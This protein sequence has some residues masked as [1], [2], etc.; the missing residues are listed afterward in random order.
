[1]PNCLFALV[2][3]SL[4]GLASAQMPEWYYSH[5]PSPNYTNQSNSNYISSP[6][7]P[8]QSNQ[9]N[10]SCYSSPNHS[11]QSNSSI[12]QRQL[13]PLLI[14][15][16]AEVLGSFDQTITGLLQ[17][18]QKRLPK[19]EVVRIER[20]LARIVAALTYLHLLPY[21]SYSHSKLELLQRAIST[22]NSVKRALV[23]FAEFQE[24]QS[25]QNSGVPEAQKLLAQSVAKV[26]QLLDL[27]M[28]KVEQVKTDSVGHDQI[29]RD[30]L[31]EDGRRLKCLA[32]ATD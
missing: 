28:G 23:Q 12:F 3:L 6:A 11:N 26:G 8:Y 9:T 10:H 4:A 31:S 14:A 7:S 30:R 21:D 1:M 15:V 20:G 2:C 22:L 16:P 27:L 17:L 18:A 24:T 5:A 32:D 25:A 29:M 19:L 13:N